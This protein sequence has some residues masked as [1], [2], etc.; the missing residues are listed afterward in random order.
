MARVEKP[1]TG[2]PAGSSVMAAPSYTGRPAP[3]DGSGWALVGLEPVVV[4][5]LHRPGAADE[6]AHRPLETRI[7]VMEHLEAPG[8]L[9]RLGARHAGARRCRRRLRMAGGPAPPPLPPPPPPPAPPPR[10]A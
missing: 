8:A 10:G 7:V 6:I 4:D 2:R 3:P 5:R 1:R 9:G